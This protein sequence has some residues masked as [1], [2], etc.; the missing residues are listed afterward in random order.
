[1]CTVS[2]IGD[3]WARKFPGDYPWTWQ[4]WVPPAEPAPYVPNPPQ[5]VPPI[6]VT[7]PFEGVS[8]D[9][10]DKLKEEMEELKKLL[11]AAKIFDEAT[12]QPDCEMDEKVALIKK[13]AEA[14]GV[15]MSKVF[16]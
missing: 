14:V 10:F 7:K 15:D 16:K 1:M 8:K 6:G 4:P 11:E 13:V 5:R 3:Q 2:N 12:G 9:E